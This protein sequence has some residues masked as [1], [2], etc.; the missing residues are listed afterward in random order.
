MGSRKAGRGANSDI[1]GAASDAVPMR[2]AVA[3][4]GCTA[5]VGGNA[6]PRS[7]TAR[8]PAPGP[9]KCRETADPRTRPKPCGDFAEGDGATVGGSRSA[10][11]SACCAIGRPASYLI[12]S[13]QLAARSLALWPGG[14]VGG[15]A[16][17][18][19]HTHAPLTLYLIGTLSWAVT[20]IAAAVALSQA[21]A[22][23]T[24]TIPIA[25][26]GVIAPPF[27]PV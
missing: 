17:L 23:R 1:M 21:G 10:P 12:P 19:D 16:Q 8:L 11:V 14:A 5:D 25:L 6:H 22:R 7:R 4:P 18:R 13:L 24:A 27:G 9:G 26:A 3:S 2:A 20:V 15:S